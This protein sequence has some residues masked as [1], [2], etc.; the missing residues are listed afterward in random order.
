MLEM[1]KSAL[2]PKP[3]LVVAIGDLEVAIED[4][5]TDRFQAYELPDEGPY[6]LRLSATGKLSGVLSGDALDLTPMLHHEEAHAS[7][8]DAFRRARAEL[9]P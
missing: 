2:Y 3:M 9:L 4:L 7:L 1:R 6:A 8:V 5:E